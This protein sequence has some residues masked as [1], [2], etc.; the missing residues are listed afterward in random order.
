MATTAATAVARASGAVSPREEPPLQA[1]L[2]RLLASSSQSQAPNRLAAR[3]L[4]ASSCPGPAPPHEGFYWLQIAEWL[5]DGFGL[6][7]TWAGKEL[8]DELCW[9]QYLVYALFRVQ[10]DLVD[11]E[12]TDPLLAVEDNRLMVEAAR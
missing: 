5:A 9:I 10:D 12:A 1:R 4:P 3:L 11:G 2:R 6:R 7:A 8:F